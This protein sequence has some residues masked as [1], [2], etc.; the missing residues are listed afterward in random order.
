MC[1]K[2]KINENPRK[3]EHMNSFA[4]AVVV[5]STVSE[6]KIRRSQETNL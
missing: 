2:K 5:A 4:S 3:V 1:Q 6:V